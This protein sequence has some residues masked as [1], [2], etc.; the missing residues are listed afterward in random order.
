MKFMI[1]DRYNYVKYL[2]KYNY[3]QRELI[4]MFEKKYRYI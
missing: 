2:R 3:F 1:K 4:K